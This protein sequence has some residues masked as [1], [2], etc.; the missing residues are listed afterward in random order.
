M[1][2]TVS[3]RRTKET[4]ISLEMD[5]DGAG[6]NRIATGIPFLDHMLTLMSRHGLIDLKL[7]AKGDIEVDW[8]HT[9][10][11]VGIVLGKALKEALG[12]MR[13]IKR[14]GFASVPMD[15]A[16]AE[17]SL[18]ISGRPFLV[19]QVEFPKKRKIKDFDADLIEDF[20]QAFA[21]NAGITLH[22]HVPYGRNVH[23]MAEAAF[24]AAGRALKEAVSLEPRAKTK[25][26][27]TKGRL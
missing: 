1:R 18:D 27:S 25:I 17:V 20:F 10:E 14:Y 4:K 6:A 21:A 15:E 16:L 2:K 7:K 19:Y 9:V 12:D 5:L 23:H 24:K 13:G 11:D 3:E 22:I 8:H 26:P